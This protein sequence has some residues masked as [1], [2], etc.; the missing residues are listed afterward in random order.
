MGTWVLINARWYKSGIRSRLGS[1]DAPNAAVERLL[2]LEYR[3]AL[4]DY[5]VSIVLRGEKVVFK[6][7]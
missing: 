6:K 7:H 3:V 2:L 5:A 4:F 1:D